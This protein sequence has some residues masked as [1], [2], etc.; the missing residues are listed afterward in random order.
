MCSTSAALPTRE[1]QP[2]RLTIHTRVLQAIERFEP[3]EWPGML[4]VM[5]DQAQS[6]WR[7]TERE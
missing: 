4:V 3:E 5:R 2:N 6:V 1:W 7:R